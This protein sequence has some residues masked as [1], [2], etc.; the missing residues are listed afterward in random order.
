MLGLGDQVGG[1]IFGPR[2]AVHDHHH[3]A[4][5]GDGIDVDL[6]VDVSL[7]QGDEEVAGPDDLVHARNALDAV[8][9]GGDGLGAAE[10]IDLGDLQLAAGG[11]QVG[12]KAPKGVGGATTASWATPA[13]WAGTAVISTVDG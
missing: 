6:A 4:G 13:T 7:G 11:Q 1:G 3:F 10:A 9:Q 8:G 2:R 5:A 12:L